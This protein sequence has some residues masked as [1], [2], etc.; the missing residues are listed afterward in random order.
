MNILTLLL[1]FVAPELKLQ[2]AAMWTLQGN[3][4]KSE[5]VLKTKGVA[6]SNPDLYYFYKL[7]NN[8]RMNNKKEALKAAQYLE[9]SPL[10]GLQERHKVVA[11]LIVADMKAWKN[12][13]FEDVA[14]D[15]SHAASRIGATQVGEKTQKIQKSI[16][17][18]LDQQIKQLED[19]QNQQAKGKGQGQDQKTAKQN[20]PN[21]SAVSPLEKSQAS[22][23]NSGTGQVN[24][25]KLAKLTEEWGRLPP[26]QQ[27]EALQRLTEGL[28]P[29]HREA[30]ENYFRNIANHKKR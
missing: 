11:M 6:A 9:N 21:S 3:Y 4:E 14:R 23:E 7:A 10:T 8:F 22:L 26:R 5:E 1:L 19:Q 2:E 16:L 27:E 20:R 29:R 15:M 18:R 24:L 25:R 28:S 30:I 13:V 17:D 12:E